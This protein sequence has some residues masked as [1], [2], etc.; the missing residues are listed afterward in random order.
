MVPA[1][2]ACS[3]AAAAELEGMPDTVTPA[4]SGDVEK[5]T[6]VFIFTVHVAAESP[7]NVS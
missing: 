3:T 7:I 5:S 2:I 6:S 4:K 1:S